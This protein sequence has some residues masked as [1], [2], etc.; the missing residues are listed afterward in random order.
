MN[1]NSFYILETPSSYHQAHVCSFDKPASG[2]ESCD[3]FLNV[4]PQFFFFFCF[5]LSVKYDIF[6]KYY[7]ISQSLCNVFPQSILRE[8]A[9]LYMM[10]SLITHIT[11]AVEKKKKKE[12]P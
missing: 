3:D 9:S 7:I 6:T 5:Y 1:I 8:L 2:N 11:V 12:I 10:H 4:F